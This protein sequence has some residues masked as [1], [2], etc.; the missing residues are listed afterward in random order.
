MCRSW[1]ARPYATFLLGLDELAYGRALQL[2]HMVY[3]WR[4]TTVEVSGSPEYRQV[5]LQML[6]CARGWL[7]QVGSCRATF[8]RPRM[9]AKC[10]GCPL[11][12]PG[13][14]LEA[15]PRPSSFLY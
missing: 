10:R 3:G 8:S 9:P 7:R 13:W 12:D 14:A 2:L 6:H 4:A 15:C 11:Y 1:R 5:I